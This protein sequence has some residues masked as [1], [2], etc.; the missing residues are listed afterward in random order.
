[1]TISHR[2]PLHIRMGSTLQFFFWWSSIF[3]SFHGFG[4]TRSS[5]SSFFTT[6]AAELSYDLLCQELWATIPGP[7]TGTSCNCAQ[8]AAT[9]DISMECTNVCH[10]C[11]LD[12]TVCLGK[13]DYGVRYNATGDHVH[14]WESYQ[15]VRSTERMNEILRVEYNEKSCTMT[16]NETLTCDCGFVQCQDGTEGMS[17][18]CREIDPR[19]F[20]VDCLGD[21]GTPAQDVVGTLLEGLFGLGFHE[22]LAEI[23][24]LS[25]AATLVSSSTEAATPEQ[26]LMVATTGVNNS[27]TLANVSSIGTATVSNPRIEV[28]NTT[29]DVN[30]S[31]TKELSNEITGNI[32]ASNS[33]IVGASTTTDINASTT[34]ENAGLTNATEITGNIT[35][36][37]STNG[38]VVN[39]TAMDNHKCSS[40]AEIHI[41]WVSCPVFP[42]FRGKHQKVPA[43]RGKLIFLVLASRIKTPCAVVSQHQ[44]QASTG[45]GFPLLELDGR[46][47]QPHAWRVH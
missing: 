37:K 43:P 22:C 12:G 32:E 28:A 11:N 26:H 33:T 16:V 6:L 23:P 8:D 39:T 18:D 38:V 31:T 13:E 1:M 41:D 36:S 25:S 30:S 27:S 44:P 42:R 35:D 21:D 15:Y 47:K 3:V 46:F 19:A 45:H 14:D 5:S 20:F 2:Q 9:G 29:T 7:E 10:Y 17:I 40:P 4:G 34:K 24:T